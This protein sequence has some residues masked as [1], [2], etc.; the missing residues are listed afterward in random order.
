MKRIFTPKETPIRPITHIPIIKAKRRKNGKYNGHEFTE[1]IRKSIHRLP[2]RFTI[3]E[4]CEQLFDIKM[5]KGYSR[6][7]I[8]TQ[9]YN[10]IYTE[11]NNMVKKGLLDKITDDTKNPKSPHHYIQTPQTKLYTPK[12]N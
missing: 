10:N 2:K 5:G 6:S 8:K 9:Y 1:Y 4:A 11:L 7:K 3:K 12:T